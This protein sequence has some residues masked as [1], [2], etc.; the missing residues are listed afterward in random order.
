MINKINNA[1]GNN[2]Y[3]IAKELNDEADN[4]ALYYCK[5]GAQVARENLTYV[6]YFRDATKSDTVA[7]IFD[8]ITTESKYRSKIIQNEYEA[9]Y[10][11]VGAYDTCIIVLL[12]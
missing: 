6:A 7:A 3:K 4:A 2:K 1:R 5:G 9:T 11:G 12:D 10:M 8:T